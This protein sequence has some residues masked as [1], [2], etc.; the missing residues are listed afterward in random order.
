LNAVPSLDR[1]TTLKTAEKLLR[2]GKL[3]LAEFEKAA[4]SPRRRFEAASLAARLYQENGKIPQAIGWFERAAEAPA[5][6]AEAGRAPL[7]ELA[8]TLEANR[9]GVRALAVCLELQTDA[10]DYRDVR[11][12]VD[13]LTKAQAGG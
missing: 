13:R 5:A 10:G 11:A 12:R 8:T 4:R 9:E 6:I 7:Y 3:D 1:E 2:Q